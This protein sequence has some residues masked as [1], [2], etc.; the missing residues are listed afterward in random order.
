[1]T[2]ARHHL[3]RRLLA[4][5]V[6]VFLAF[7]RVAAAPAG[8]Q[9]ALLEGWFAAQTNVHSWSA[10]FKQTRSLKALSQ[11]LVATGRVWVAF[12]DR[13]RWELGDPPQT[14]A[15]RQ[16][17]W[18]FVIYPRLKRAEKYPLDDKQPGPWR[19]ALSLLEA[20]FPRSRA[21]LDSR[22]HVLS[23]VQTNSI[24][25]VVLQPK[26][27]SARRMMTEIRV[28]FA[29]RD[30]SLGSTEVRMIDGSSLR[31]DFSHASV[32]PQ[33]AAD[34]FSEKLD[35]DFQVVEPSKR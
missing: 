35:P 33:L 2:V 29:S 30:F 20:G 32:N 9:A 5:A 18:L 15:L 4:G 7:F 12:P 11:P 26:S 23:V 25:E 8:E 24:V 13:F 22:F 28:S 3:G 6:S 14:I 21:D 19:D 34:C 16:P 27:A 17:K 10:E 31:N 1:M